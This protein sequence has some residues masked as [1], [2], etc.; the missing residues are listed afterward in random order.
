MEEF[1]WRRGH[2][3]ER[4]RDEN[5]GIWVGSFVPCSCQT[6]AGGWRWYAAPAVSMRR[7][8][9]R[10]GKDK[11]DWSSL[12]P[13]FGR[14][15]RACA[16]VRGNGQELVWLVRS[17]FSLISLLFFSFSIF[18]ICLITEKFVE[19]QNSFIRPNEHCSSPKHICF[20]NYFMHFGHLSYLCDISKNR[21]L[22]FH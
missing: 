22:A 17:F 4:N 1:S 3:F 12:L 10:K 20:K 7:K 15:G 16:R 2:E 13:G 21:F 14:C 9:N 11:R 8:K 6:Q 19:K 5:L 18:Q